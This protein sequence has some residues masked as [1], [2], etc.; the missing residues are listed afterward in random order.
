[1]TD[2]MQD[3]EK[4]ES[5]VVRKTDYYRDKWNELHEKPGSIASFNLAAC[6]GQVVWL[7]YRKLY[8]PLFWAVVVLIADIALRSY[9]EY[10]QRLS[11]NSLAAWDALAVLLYLAVFGLLGN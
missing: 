6:L 7:A 5:F 2:S 1:M 9:V 8:G 11:E 3:D 10:E 4:I